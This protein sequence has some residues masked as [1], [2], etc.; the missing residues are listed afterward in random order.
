M[1]S[2]V[3]FMLIGLCAVAPVAALAQGAAAPAGTSDAARSKAPVGAR[4]PRPADI[5]A[6]DTRARDN[7]T[8][9]KLDE[10]DKRLKALTRG[11]IC[12]NC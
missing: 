10:A 5:P 2:I 3:R 8:Q 11:S 7:A 6:A 1:V 12:S 9:R 4:Q